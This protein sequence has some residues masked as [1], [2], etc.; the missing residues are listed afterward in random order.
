MFR[1]ELVQF[2]DFAVGLAATEPVSFL[3]IPP[4]WRELFVA[5]ALNGVGTMLSR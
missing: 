4:P 2:S 3:S 5:I 1:R